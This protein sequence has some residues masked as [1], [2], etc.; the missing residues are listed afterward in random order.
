MQLDR[1]KRRDFIALLGGAAAAWPLAARAQPGDR[2]RHIGALMPFKEQDAQ[3][4]EIV[5]AL[6]QG[7]SDRGWS[8][9]RNLDVKFRW[10][11]DDLE[12]RSAYAAESVA[13]SPDVIFACY[14]AQLATLLAR[15][16]ARHYIK[17]DL[18]E[19]LPAGYPNL[20]RVPQHH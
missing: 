16:G 17:K 11:G 6:R 18:Q 8:E 4:Q 5:A 1:I 9:G 15:F 7:L 2:T 12:R 3:G 13:A 14:A 10:I 19:F 20:L